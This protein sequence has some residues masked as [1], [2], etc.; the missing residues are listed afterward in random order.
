MLYV[1][2]EAYLGM[3]DAVLDDKP[4]Y[5][6]SSKNLKSGKITRHA[7]AEKPRGE[8]VVQTPSPAFAAELAEYLRRRQ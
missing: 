2:V 1:P 4:Q 5:W 6:W 8:I 3:I 7:A